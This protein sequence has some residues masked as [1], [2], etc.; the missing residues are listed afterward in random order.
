MQSNHVLVC[1]NGKQIIRNKLSAASSENKSD[2]S[3]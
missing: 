2:D 1:E 3:D